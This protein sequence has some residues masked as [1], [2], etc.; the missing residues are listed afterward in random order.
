M[1]MVLYAV[2]CIHDYTKL[3]THITFPCMYMESIGAF[4]ITIQVIGEAGS[5]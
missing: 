5:S 4:T 2:S 3:Y 1:V